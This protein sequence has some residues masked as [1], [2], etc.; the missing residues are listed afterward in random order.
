[1]KALVN[2]DFKCYEGAV[3]LYYIFVTGRGK[4][5]RI[6]WNFFLFLDSQKKHLY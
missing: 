5:C 6:L 3:N 2:E 4:T 1:M